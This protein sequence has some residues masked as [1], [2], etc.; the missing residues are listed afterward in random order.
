MC[1]GSALAATTGS[2]DK[3]GKEAILELMA[4]V[5]RS[6][7]TPQRDLEKP[8]L[9]PIEDTFSIAGRGTVVTGRVEQGIIKTGDSVEIV[10]FGPTVKTTV[11]GAYSRDRALP[12]PWWQ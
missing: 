7:P 12:P 8:F 6:I 2:D 11:T 4:A 9:M 3:L 10:G 5:E 1:R